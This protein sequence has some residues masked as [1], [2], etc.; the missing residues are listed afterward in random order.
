MDLSLL[1]YPRPSKWLREAHSLLRT[2][3][4]LSSSGQQASAQGFIQPRGFR[5]LTILG[6]GT[7]SSVQRVR[8][9]LVKGQP[10]LAGKMVDEGPQ[11]PLN[12]TRGRRSFDPLC[13]GK[14]LV[15]RANGS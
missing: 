14:S 2:A 11:G 10:G 1:S 5:P 15:A 8:M 7:A 13:P 6:T 4:C 9:R 12:M 3:V